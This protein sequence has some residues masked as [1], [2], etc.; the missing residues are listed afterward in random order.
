MLSE[1]HFD[2]LVKDG[3]HSTRE[4]TQFPTKTERRNFLVT[5]GLVVKA[6]LRK[7]GLGSLGAAVTLPLSHT[8][9]EPRIEHKNF[10]DKHS[11]SL[12]DP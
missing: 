1:F 5:G 4:K 10:E 8:K 9:A 2:I 6:W 3:G 12:E 11:A 7:E